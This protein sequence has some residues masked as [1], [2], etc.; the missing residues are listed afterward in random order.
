M[1]TSTLT[2]P[3]HL[4]GP[5]GLPFPS[6]ALFKL[7]GDRLR[8]AVTAF[9]QDNGIPWVRF[10]KD[11]VGGK[12]GLMRPYLDLTP[13]TGRDFRRWVWLFWGDS[14]APPRP[15]TSTVTLGDLTKTTGTASIVHDHRNSD[16]GTQQHDKGT[17]PS[18]RGVRVVR[19][20]DRMTPTHR[21]LA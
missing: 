11:D 1:S 3:S 10:G 21:L 14:P 7:L 8:R 9:A 12:L 13:S 19:G 20:V 16:H 5:P 4:S 17:R 6:P 15:V 2:F 18:R